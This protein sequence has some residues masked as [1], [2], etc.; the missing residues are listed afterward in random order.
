MTK[1]KIPELLAPAGSFDALKAAVFAGADAVYLGGKNFGAR[2]YAANFSNADIARAVEFAHRYGVKV[3]VTVNTIVF[4][5]E[6]PEVADYL[7][8][9]S[10]AGV[11]AVLVQDAGVLET[12]REV[13]PDM[14][15]HASTQ[16]T[17]HNAEGIRYAASQGI[18]RVVL[19]RETSL[20]NLKAIQ[21]QAAECGVE[22]EIFVHGAICYCYS[23]QCLFSSVI[24]GR[25]GNR[26]M[27]A[28]PCRKQYTLLADGD[29][30]PTDGNYVLSPRDL[31]LYPYLKEISETGVAALKIEGRMKTPEYV[32]VV[33]N[34]Y[35][36]AL[37]A[38]ADGTFEPRKEDLEDLAF[39]FNRGFT[40]GYLMGDRGA[41]FMNYKKPDNRGVFAGTVTGID[42]KRGKA[43]V[44]IEGPVP[45]TGDGIVYRFAGRESGL[46]LNKEPYIFPEGDAYKIP[47]PAD[48]V[49]G[50]ELWITH[51]LKTDR[52][53]AALLSKAPEGR[54]PL[55]VSASVDEGGFL[56]LSAGDISTKSEIPFMEAKNRP[57]SCEQLE[58]QISKTGGTPFVVRS[59][60]MG[61][62]GTKF[63]PQGAVADTRRRLLEACEVRLFAKPERR[64]RAFSV[65][66]PAKPAAC[67]A[68]VLQVYTDSVVCA[69]TAY[70]AGV[71]QI[72]FEGKEEI[73]DIP[74]IYK[75][76]RIVSENEFEKKIAAIPASAK[77]VM[78]DNAGMADSIRGVEKFAGPGFNITNAVS[79]NRAGRFCRQ[80]C[81]S[82]ELSGKQIR[83]LMAGLAGYA[84]PPRVEVLVQGNLE[85]M[86]SENCIPAT[87]QGCRACNQAWALKDKTGRVFRIRSDASHRTHILNSAETCLVQYVK[88]LASAGVFVFSIDAR[89]RSPEYIR[90]MTA[91]YRKAL[92]GGDA[93][94]LK[95]EI[96]E[97]SSGGVTAGHYLRGTGYE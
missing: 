27:C 8:F 1:I 90:R 50:A 60:E 51:R 28:Q 83:R 37:D 74:V 12:A 72:V 20:A 66:A 87:A 21:A 22:L 6:L 61:Y 31:C 79:A 35:R 39:A 84:H 2:A 30:V 68:P 10:D 16:M 40:K 14:P 53:A 76:P 54:I 47:A 93:K 67:T 78:I 3:Y 88:E 82:P 42:E 75:L 64:A 73:Y 17:L 57:F 33:T 48:V 96:R 70:S 43:I 32:A 91:I 15:V 80:V 95:E 49:Q 92:E 58:A 86:I 59:I 52:R 18:S 71:E 62:D 69:K 81:L 77:G 94:A 4:D 44:Q 85:V 7:T 26:G 63:M 46:S 56:V 9:L 89:G 5:D 13:A 65:P 45:D 24:G 29:M 41:A 34:I 23:G 11:D 55:D 38:V 25:S 36:R 97:I 19:A